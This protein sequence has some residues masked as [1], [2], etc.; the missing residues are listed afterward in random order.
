MTVKVP[1]QQFAADTA[2]EKS[3]IKEAK[4]KGH[5]GLIIEND[6][7]NELEKDVFYV[8]FEPTQIKSATDNAGTF[9]PE[10]PDIRFALMD[11]S[12]EQIQDH[13]NILKPFVGV[14]IDMKEELYRNY[15]KE[16]GV[17][18]PDEDADLFFRMAIK[19]NRAEI[20]KASLKKNKQDTPL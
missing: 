16:K 10:N 4:K 11:Y 2:L 1:P 18:I 19:E 14:N 13:V 15:L 6:T 3:L 8:V 12:E 9:D 20:L 17:D 7:D 5:D